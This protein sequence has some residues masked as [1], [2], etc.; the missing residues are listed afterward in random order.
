M[1]LVDFSC[2]GACFLVT[3]IAITITITTSMRK[4]I[5]A[6]TDIPMIAPVASPPADSSNSTCTW[7]DEWYRVTIQTIIYR[8]LSK[9]AR[10]TRQNLKLRKVE[11][12]IYYFFNELSADIYIAVYRLSYIS[13]KEQKIRR[14]GSY[15][16]A[17]IRKIIQK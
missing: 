12:N 4:A 3:T 8:L 14:F 7:K 10:C 2:P 16:T 5:T 9:G 11:T 17:I 6:P 1:F 15:T 13:N